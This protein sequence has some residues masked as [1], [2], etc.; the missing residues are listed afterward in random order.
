MLFVEPMKTNN[1]KILVVD[2]DIDLQDI[3]VGFFKPRGY[4]MIVYSDAE[5][6]YEDLKSEKLTCDVILTDLVLPTI[7]GIEF[8]KKVKELGLDVQ[9][10]VITVNKKVKTATESIKAGA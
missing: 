9:I 1:G 6:A 7:T 8:T 3:I 5:V 2:D 4:E 10:V